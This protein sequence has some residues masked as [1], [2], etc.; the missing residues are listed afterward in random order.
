MVPTT[1]DRVGRESASAMTF[2]DPLMSYIL[3][4]YDCKK[5]DHRRSRR[6]EYLFRSRNVRGLCSVERGVAIE[7]ALDFFLLEKQ[8]Q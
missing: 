1:D 7:V 4:P 3:S 5:R 6:L 2:L 8:L